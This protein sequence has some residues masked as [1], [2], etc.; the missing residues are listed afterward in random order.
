M[1]LLG[2]NLAS[3]LASGVATG[4]LN[5][6]EE[7][8]DTFSATNIAQTAGGRGFVMTDFES[9]LW[10][11]RKPKAMPEAEAQKKVARVVR[12]IESVA[13]AQ[14]AQPAAKF[15]EQKREVR[16]AVE[17]LVEQMPGFDWMAVYTSILDG[18]KEQE[19]QRIATAEIERIR[20]MTDEEDDMLILMM[21]GA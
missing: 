4:T 18:L 20:L 12:V 2:L 1:L 6:T 5:A 8:S 11:K 19:A 17:P 15:A 10:W 16:E 7:G 3:G 14:I 13:K 21:L 9:P